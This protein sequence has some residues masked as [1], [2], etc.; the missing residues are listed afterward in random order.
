M[1]YNI[2]EVFLSLQGEGLRSGEA[3]VF[4]RFAGCNLRCNGETVDQAFQPI[5][6]TEFTSSRQYEIDRLLDEIVEISGACRWIILT[7]GEPTQQVTADLIAALK[8]AGYK[9]AIETNGTNPVLAGIDWITVSP[10]IAEHAIR[11]RTASE[12]KY[13]RG[14]GQ[15][16]PRTVVKADHYLISPAFDGSVIQPK[17]LQ[18]CIKLCLDNPLWR[19]SCQ[20]H[21]WWSV[22]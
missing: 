3:S 1:N 10:K 21:K 22:R 20:N 18:W 8:Q 19:L 7:G 9:L 5:C 12:V 14:Y 4:L 6:D 2:N 11:Q 15:G 17:T 16:I 13:V